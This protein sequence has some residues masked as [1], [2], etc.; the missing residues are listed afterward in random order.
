MRLRI[1]GEDGVGKT[2]QSTLLI[3]VPDG[4]N[5]EERLA[6]L[7]LTLYEQDGKTLID[8]V[9]FGSPAAVAGMEF[10]QEILSVKAPTE[11]WSKELMWFPG[12]LL[13]GL[14]VWLQRRRVVRQ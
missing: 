6:N 1:Q 13:F 10:D 3:A 14:I 11:R 5:G 8:S 2:R 12:F 7:G 4:A 9:T